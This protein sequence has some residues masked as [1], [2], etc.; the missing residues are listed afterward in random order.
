MTPFRVAVTAR[1]AD[2][3]A[4]AMRA[5]AETVGAVF[6]ARTEAVR[7]RA[8]QRDFARSG[9]VLVVTEQDTLAIRLATEMLVTL[10]R[11]ESRRST[12]ASSSRGPAACRC[13]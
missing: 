9:R 6:L 8:V 7:A 11:L 4:V 5:V 12:P 1:D 10:R 13:S 2:E 3:L